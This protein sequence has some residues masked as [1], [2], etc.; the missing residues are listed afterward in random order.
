MTPSLDF[1]KHAEKFIRMTLAELRP[2]LLKAHGS[3]EHRLKED[4]T[5]VTEMDELV[6]NRL[7][8]A[9]FEVDPGIAFSGEETGAD[10]DK[11]TFWLVDPI[12]GTDPFIRGLP[13]STNMVALIDDGQPVLSVIYNFFLD[14]YYLAIKGQGSTCNG[15]PIHVSNRPIDRSLVISGGGFARGGVI[16]ASD[17]LRPVVGGL[18]QMNASGFELSAIASGKL[19]GRIGWRPSAKPWDVAPGALLVTEAGG[20]VE[21]IGVAGYDYRNTNTIIS[22]P[23]IFDD[24]MKFTLDEIARAGK[25]PN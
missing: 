4:K 20:R 1:L 10:Y 5:V 22:N 11:K 24:L 15:H 25:Q 13:F 9:L 16:G 6:E 18:V 12:D 19:D 3:I 17:R 14:E 8:K 2:E 7:R 21:N 23:E